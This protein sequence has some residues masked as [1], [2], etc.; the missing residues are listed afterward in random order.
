[1]PL[2]LHSSLVKVTQSC[3]FVTPWTI[4][5]LELSTENTGVG[6]LSLFQG[7]FPTQGINPGSSALQADSLPAKLPGKPSSFLSRGVILGRKR[8][9]HVVSRVAG[10]ALGRMS[11]TQGGTCVSFLGRVLTAWGRGKVHLLCARDPLHCLLMKPMGLFS[12]KCFK[13]HNMKHSRLQRK[14]IILKQNY[15]NVK[16]TSDRLLHRIL[17]F[18]IKKTISK[19]Q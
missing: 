5:S 6:S 7:I 11:A 1:M 18:L 13:I 12:E 16:K 4:Q 17:H 9:G 14:L 8:D 2:R 19:Q 3:L 15:Q 10:E